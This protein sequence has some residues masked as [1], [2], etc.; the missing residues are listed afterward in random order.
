M[1][2]R[3]ETALVEF[4]AT[5]EGRDSGSIKPQLRNA[6][7][8]GFELGVNMTLANPHKRDPRRDCE[9][10][11]SKAV[12]DRIGHGCASCETKT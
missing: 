7:L 8:A 3:I 11:F 2:I 1:D 12:G 5:R 4:L 10:G 9:H 6:F